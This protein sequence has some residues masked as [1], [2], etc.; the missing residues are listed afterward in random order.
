MVYGGATVEYTS[1]MYSCKT[2]QV[3]WKMVLTADGSFP[4]YSQR[5]LVSGI[6]DDFKTNSILK[7]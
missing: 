4:A 3:V 7:E 1:T 5:K 6:F 2:Q